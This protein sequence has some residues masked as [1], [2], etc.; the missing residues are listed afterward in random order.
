MCDLKNKLSTMSKEELL[1]LLNKIFESENECYNEIYATSIFPLLAQN[2]LV[3]IVLKR[4]EE[5]KNVAHIL[6]YISKHNLTLFVDKYIENPNFN[7]KIFLP[8]ILQED[9]KRLLECSKNK[10]IPL[11][12][13]YISMFIF[14]I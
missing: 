11:S 1:D 2:D 13:D 7:F 8:F 5:N 10:I 6:P 3:D 12:E 4:I 14:E 9:V